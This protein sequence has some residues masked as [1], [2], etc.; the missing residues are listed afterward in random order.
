MTYSKSMMFEAFADWY[1]ADIATKMLSDYLQAMMPELE[2]SDSIL[3]RELLRIYG[4]PEAL[5]QPKP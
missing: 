5:D 1:K 4:V 3:F 2:S